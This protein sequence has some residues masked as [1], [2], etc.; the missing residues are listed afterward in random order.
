LWLSFPK[1][2][3]LSFGV[4]FYWPYALYL[5]LSFYF[6]LLFSFF[7]LR[8][9]L[10]SYFKGIRFG[11]SLFASLLFGFMHSGGITV[12]G[13]LLLKLTPELFFETNSI[14]FYRLLSYFF[15][16][17]FVLP[18]AITGVFYFESRDGFL[19]SRGGFWLSIFL[20]KSDLFKVLYF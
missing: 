9:V 15:L 8:D 2:L 13:L 6:Y 12:F 14:F 11:N 10:F 18:G 5:L 3:S 17:I 4:L 1:L 19:S 16:N 20:N 7:W